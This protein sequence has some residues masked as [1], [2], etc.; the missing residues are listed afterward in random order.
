[1]FSSLPKQNLYL[2]LFVLNLF[3]LFNSNDVVSY[4]SADISKHNRRQ[5]P[6]SV[7]SF[8]PILNICF[9]KM[10][11]NIYLSGIGLLFSSKLIK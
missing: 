6:S 11:L 9:V 1:M 10:D 2:F 4:F 3:M 7:N 8:L 5:N